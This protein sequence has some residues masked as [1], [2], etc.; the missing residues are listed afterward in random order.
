MGVSLLRYCPVGPSGL[1]W[2]R[3]E[4]NKPILFAV[5]KMT[6]ETL[7]KVL[8]YGLGEGERCKKT[9]RKTPYHTLLGTVTLHLAVTGGGRKL[10]IYFC[11]EILA[12]AIFDRFQ[13]L[14]LAQEDGLTWNEAGLKYLGE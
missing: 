13:V 4:Y 3:G 8:S 1:G 11:R 2:T 14:R 9:F 7:G 12:A 5:A 10:L 6:D